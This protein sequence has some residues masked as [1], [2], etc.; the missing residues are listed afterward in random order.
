M[1]NTT[2]ECIVACF[3][4]GL[5]MQEVATR[6]LL[7]RETVEKAVRRWMELQD[8]KEYGFKERVQP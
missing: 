4:A 1:P 2:T 3:K 8:F 6:L 7:P 5:T